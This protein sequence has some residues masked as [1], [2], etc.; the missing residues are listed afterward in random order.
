MESGFSRCVL[1]S[2]H[3]AARD[4]NN[5]VHISIVGD[6]FGLLSSCRPSCWTRPGIIQLLTSYP[7]RLPLPSLLF[8]HCRQVAGEVEVHGS[9]LRTWTGTFV[10]PD[11]GYTRAQL[12]LWICVPFGM[13]ELEI[14]TFSYSDDEHGRTSWEILDGDSEVMDPSAFRRI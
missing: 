5:P 11:T 3:V 6:H 4:V 9:D 7:R 10:K 2:C 1:P 13:Y 8:L 12:S 14:N